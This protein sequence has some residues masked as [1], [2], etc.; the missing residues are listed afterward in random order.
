MTYFKVAAVKGEP[1][2]KTAT[3]CEWVNE[4]ISLEP[5]FLRKIAIETARR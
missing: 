3:F 5:D 1:N 2:L 4:V